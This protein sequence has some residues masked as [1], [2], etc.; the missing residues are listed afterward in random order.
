MYGDFAPNSPMAQ[1]PR[2][3]LA[4][5]ATFST[6]LDELMIVNKST[7]GRDKIY[8]IVQYFSR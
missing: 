4:L 5:W 8:R 7:D 6:K 1:A 2:H 3:Q